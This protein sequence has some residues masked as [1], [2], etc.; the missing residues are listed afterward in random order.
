M[1]RARPP[2]RELARS[3]LPA[4]LFAATAAALLVP[5]VRLHPHR[6]DP[7]RFP[8]FQPGRWDARF[9]VARGEAAVVL[10][11]VALRA[12][13]HLSS[14]GVVALASPGREMS[15]GPAASPTATVVEL[16]RGGRLDVRPAQAVRLHAIDVERAG[17]APVA[18]LAA[19]LGLA[20]L[21]GSVAARSGVAAAVV[22]NGAFALAC[23]AA[24]RGTLGALAV[25]AAA[26]A[27][28]PALALGAVVLPTVA[29]ALWARP[30]RSERAGAV[31][32]RRLPLAAAALLLVSCLLQVAL[33]PQPLLIGDPST[34]WEIGGRFRDAF[35]AVGGPATLADAIETLRPYGGLAAT[36]AVYAVLRVL[37]DAPV[38]AYLAHAL[39]LAGMAFFLVRSAVRLGGAAAGA[40]LVAALLL[41]PTFP[42]VAGIVQPEPFVL[43]LWAF[44]L[45]RLLASREHP[46]PH[47]AARAGLAFAGGLALHPQG[48]AF[49]LVA[50][51]LAIALFA[52]DFA[53]R[54]AARARL[55]AFGAGVLPL[56]FAVFLGEAWARPAAHELDERHGFFAY[57][58]DLPL[59]FW[60]WMDTGG[61]QGPLRLDES[62]YAQGLRAE[63]DDKGTLSGAGRLAYTARFLAA[64]AGAAA[65]TVL[66]NLHRLYH[67]PDNP[68]RRGWVVPY[69]AHVLLHRSAVA[70]VLVG[71]PFLLARGGAVLLVPFAILGATYPLYHVFNKY[72]LPAAPFVLLGAAVVVAGRPRAPR[73]LLAALLVAGGAALVGVPP[74]AL[75][76]MPAE[77]ARGLVVALHLGG[78]AVSFVLAARAFATDRRGRALT[79]LAA[80]VLLA[81]AAVVAA[82]DPR[83]ASFAAPLRE[84]ARHEVDLGAEGLRRLTDGDGYLLL[85]LTL[86]GGDPGSL[87]IAFDGGHRV[88]GRRLE[89]TMP[90]FGLFTVRGHRD[91]RAERQWWRLPFRPEMAQGTRVGLTVTGPEGV[92]HG[93]IGDPGATRE[94]VL[95]CGEW[96]WLSVYRAMHEGEYRLATHYER[97]GPRASR[98]GE[99]VLP[100]VW[101]VRF[102]VTEG[103]WTLPPPARANRWRVTAVF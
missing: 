70:L 41:Y 15:V 68:F 22:A 42:L 75:L 57:T 97:S 27:V 26:D 83:W 98:L 25:Q 16:P 79:A 58:S 8:G 80:F 14:P 23:A 24:L 45:D 43:L 49:L 32:G 36:G 91:P 60:L 103:G 77:L 74:L 44:A 95:S 20:I 13:L 31:P 94:H 100:G 4:L 29:V 55:G 48:L 66:T 92:I 38:A 18:R 89:P 52:A 101:E 2:W 34:Y 39:A 87:E 71:V 63:E 10:P 1:S 40:L 35:A 78:L 72:A 73:A 53:R 50:L 19:L 85:D 12:T 102:V 6:S 28:R 86:P 3:A 47:A 37:H 62:R 76:G 17:P 99:R 11:E 54:P 69:E 81:P 64:N 65:R 51:G 5:S 21:A 84:G 33:R 67:Q 30:R 9:R 56:V 96:P 90:S 88:A 93:R 59:G 7:E 82:T 46:R 61:W